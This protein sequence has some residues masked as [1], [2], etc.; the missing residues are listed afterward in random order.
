MTAPWVL[1]FPWKNHQFE[2]FVQFHFRSDIMHELWQIHCTRY[3][4]DFGRFYCP[5]GSLS[6]HSL[7]GRNS[8]SVA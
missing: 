2:A 8:F 3:Q 5:P 1:V 6:C 4:S 7:S